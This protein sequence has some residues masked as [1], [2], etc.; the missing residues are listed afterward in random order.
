MD[1]AEGS[2]WLLSMAGCVMSV[3]QV[4]QL[5]YNEIVIIIVAGE[6]RHAINNE[7]VWRSGGRQEYFTAIDG[8]L[9]GTQ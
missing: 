3:K 5:G 8:R 6:F 9:R 7:R 1:A 4:V 2:A